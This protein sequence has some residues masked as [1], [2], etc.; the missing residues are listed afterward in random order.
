MAVFDKWRRKAAASIAGPEVLASYTKPGWLSRHRGLVLTVMFVVLFF[1]SALFLLI[2]RFLIVQFVAPLAILALLIIWALPEREAIPDRLLNKL[3]IAFMVAMIAWPNYL[4]LDLP[5]LPWITASRLIGVPMVLMLLICLS[6]STK[7]RL[8]L[9]S[10]LAQSQTVSKMMLAFTIIVIL[11]VGYSTSPS[12]SVNHLIIALVNWIA[13]FIVALHFFSTPGNVNRFMWLMWALVI[14]W[15]GMA[16]WEWQYSQVPWGQNI[17]SFLAVEDES[18]QRV[19]A[20]SARSATGIYRVQ[21]KYTTPLGLSEYMAFMTP[22]L[23]HFAVES[24]KLAVRI[25]AAITLATMFWVIDVTDSRLGVVGFMLSF[26]FYLLIWGARRWTLH[27]DS[28]FGPAVTL[29]YPLLFV[30]FIISTFTVRRVR[31]MVWGDGAQ[32]ASDAG[33]QL[34]L[35]MGIVDLMAR[36]WGHGIGRGAETLGMRNLAGILTIDNYFLSILLE[37]GIIGFVVYYGMFAVAAVRGG[38]RSIKEADPETFWIAP[39][40]ITLVNFIVIKWVLSQQEGHPLIFCILGM[41]VALQA[42]ATVKTAST[43]AA[44][45]TNSAIRKRIVAPG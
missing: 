4:A 1:Y 32:A 35:E 26:M 38:L 10:I 18:V 44:A 13:I 37:I 5:P 45:I 33:R 25:F 17:P 40:S 15:V 24:R 6:Q 23:L 30:L 22:F 7:F 41:V 14:F 39:A 21:G 43:E 27:R 8:H 34:Q 9:K 3:F 20:G 29:A 19:L 36:P 12:F 2:G 42:R 28:I 11:S 16:Y 31:A